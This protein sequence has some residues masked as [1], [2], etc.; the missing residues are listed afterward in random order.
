[1]SGLFGAAGLI[2]TSALIL[3]L[4]LAV[5]MLKP[6]DPDVWNDPLRSSTLLLSDSSLHS[7][8]RRTDRFSTTFRC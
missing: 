7:I 1:M 4:I 8:L 2:L 3:A 5:V 6:I